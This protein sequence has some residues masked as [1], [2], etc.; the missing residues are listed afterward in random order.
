M[1]ARHQFQPSPSSLTGKVGTFLG[2]SLLT[3]DEACGSGSKPLDEQDPPH[4]PE[5]PHPSPQGTRVSFLPHPTEAA[6][7][8]CKKRACSEW[9]SSATSIPH[10]P[11]QGQGQRVV[12][13]QFSADMIKPSFRSSGQG[14]CTPHSMSAGCAGVTPAFVDSGCRAPFRCP[15]C[16]RGRRR[17]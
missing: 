5:F 2:D 10:P 8:S 17:P 9:L 1:S 11:G 12:S 14:R 13:I 4:S 6:L 15:R 7:V 16:C 3:L